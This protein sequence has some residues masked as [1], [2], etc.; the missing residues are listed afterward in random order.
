M[1][2]VLEADLSSAAT[3][4]GAQLKMVHGRELPQDIRSFRPRPLQRRADACNLRE[5]GNGSTWLL[6]R[7]RLVREDGDCII[8]TMK[9][10]AGPECEARLP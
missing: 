8:I 3:D 6:V 9:R 4:L 2:P 5:A 7:R 1:S 10:Q